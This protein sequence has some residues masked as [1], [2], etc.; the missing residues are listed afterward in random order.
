MN[1]DEA[2]ARLEA[3]AL[4]E[5]SGDEA[6]QLEARLKEDAEL[7]SE[8]DDVVQLGELLREGLQQAPTTQLSAL[9]RAR[10]RW[11]GFRPFGFSKGVF[12][13]PLAT[14]TA[15]LLVLVAPPE[16]DY[17]T[18]PS[19]K[20]AEGRGAASV[21]KS[22]DAE[23]E[24][25]DQPLAVAPLPQPEA[26]AAE[27]GPG[28]PRRPL[29]PW[30][31]DRGTAPAK[32]RPP[33][34]G[35]VS[36]KAAEAPPSVEYHKFRGSR[37]SQPAPRSDDA[38]GNDDA[39]RPDNAKPTMA[40]PARRVPHRRPLRRPPRERAS[41]QDG[42]I[43]TS[44]EPVSTF[45]IDVDTASYGRMR[46]AAQRKQVPSPHTRIEE[47]VNYFDYDYPTP[48]GEHP[49]SIS[50][51]TAR[52]PW[53]DTHGLVRIGLKATNRTALTQGN[54]L[55]F[56]IDV[57]GSM[58]ADEKLPLLKRALGV[59]TRQL[60]RK[61]WVSIVVY[62]GRS[63]VLLPP[64]RGDEKRVIMQTVNALESTGA[65]NGSDGIRT[66]Y[67]LARQHFI[68]S[69]MNRV[70]LATDGDFNVGISDVNELE[71]L[72]GQQARSGV[73]LSVLGF[74]QST[75]G[76]QRLER[77]ADRGNGNYAFI[78]GLDEARK[79]LR[80]ELRRTMEVVAKD[81]K[82]QVEFSTEAVSSYRLL[83]YD[84]RRLANEDFDDDLK[85]AGEIG[86]GQVVTALYE[87][88]PTRGAVDNELVTVNLRYKQPNAD[89]SQ[90]ISQSAERG[91]VQFRSASSDFRFA[92]AATAFGML[93]RE[94]RDRGEMTYADVARWA[95]A[96]QSGEDRE[97]RAQFV[98][99][100]GLVDAAS[101]ASASDSDE[102]GWNDCDPPYYFLDGIR[103]LKPECL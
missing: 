87:V 57:S 1:D 99:L 48:H 27:S 103:R 24:T 94:Y 16:R 42:F 56:L 83:G 35:S 2:R 59:L 31:H 13:M 90:L 22:G 65:T 25:P 67:E 21:T 73:F 64:T 76:D 20:W 79:V 39:K 29:K 96:A 93:L 84:N 60:T 55:V 32:P 75:Q 5:L 53:N 98:K 72:I 62:A 74:G 49:V 85:D 46:F 40:R 86:A 34:A 52:A 11:R 77:L 43:D 17:A 50:I 66:A 4:G 14:A 36:G 45:S 7:A 41:N 10:I 68:E 6:E 88:V 38:K 92:A 12:V 101:K 30:G 97:R 26:A 58:N 3:H 8:F 9:Q 100:V 33:Y 81:V 23:V 61:D 37:P 91:F 69:G 47:L 18:D 80:D 63:A 89:E 78:D 15:L 28:M 19:D 51:D 54:N 71:R 102:R 82:L 44:V 70:F 95:R